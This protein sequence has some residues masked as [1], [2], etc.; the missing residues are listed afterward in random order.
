MLRRTGGGSKGVWSE[1]GDQAAPDRAEPNQRGM[2]TGL[3]RGPLADR[4]SR[5]Q[6]GVDAARAVSLRG[7]ESHLGIFV[8]DAS[9]FCAMDQREERR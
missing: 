4:A 5:A 1:S 3:S 8:G 2:A 9:G 6:A 7:G